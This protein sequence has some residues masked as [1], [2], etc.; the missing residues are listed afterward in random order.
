MTRGAELDQSRVTVLLDVRHPLAYLALGPAIALGVSEGIEINWL[1]LA[2][3]PL[4]APSIPAANDDRGIRHRRA[5]AT[6]IAREIEVYAAAQ[7]LVV[8]EYYRNAEA[9]AAHLGSLWVRDRHP[10]QHV[11]YLRESFRA[12]WALELD[13]SSTRAV[14]ALLDRMDADGSGFLAWATG[15]GPGEAAALEDAL[16]NYGLFGV[17]AYIVEDEVFYGRQHLPMIR[18]ILR[19]RSGPG[20]I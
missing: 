11:P 12:Y 9:G 18:W 20:P 13:A 5:R 8:R 16:R 17:P 14:A 3:P 6:A 7:G 10:E 2:T 1:P 19:G 4:H 15:D